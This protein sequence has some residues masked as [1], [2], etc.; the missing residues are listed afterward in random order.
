MNRSTT[1]AVAG[2]TAVA[3]T[4]APVPASAADSSGAQLQEVTPG[5]LFLANIDDDANAC[6]SAAQR[7]TSEAV[8]R[9]EAN[10]QRFS[11]EKDALAQLPDQEQAERDFLALRRSHRWEQ[12]LADRQLAACNDAA[13]AVVNGAADER[14]L[15]RLRVTPWSNAPAAATA[16]VTTSGKVR[17]FVKRARWEVADVLTV[18]ELRRGVDLGL[19]GTDVVRD[20][21]DWDG[22]AV[23]T[24]TVTVAGAATTRAV[25]LRAAPVLTQLNTQRLQRVFAAESDDENVRGWHAEIAKVAPLTTLATADDGWTQDLFEPAYQKVDGNGMRVLVP[26]VN[27]RHRQAA[28]A[29]YTQLRGRDVAVVHIADVPQADSD[30]DNTYDSMGNLETMPPTPGHPNGTIVVG[31]TPSARVMTFFRAQGAQDVVT[32]DTGWLTVGHVDEFIQFLPVDGGWKAIVAD[33]AAGLTMLAGVPQKEKLH[34]NLP[35]LEWPYDERIDK[36]TVAEFRADDQF[37]DTNR[38]AARRIDQNIA[39][40]G[41]P[42]SRIVRIPV[43][44]TARSFDW[45]LAQ[46]AIDGMDDG[47]EKDDAIVAL[48]AM[49]YAVGETPNLINGLVVNGNRYVAPKP[50]GPLLGGHDVFETAATRALATVGYQVGYA[51]DL[52]SAHVG[53]G[54]IHCSTNT[55]RDYLTS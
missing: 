14:D 44:F 45:A 18:A 32:V 55:F 39:T 48:N 54:E 22:T 35:T 49:R 25:R 46:S 4:V 27:D 42:A 8:A 6:R 20:R 2:L 28:R 26:S 16:R 34:G 38:I 24:L 36:R 40:L 41:L 3:L 53:E 10:E 29:A 51:D 37:V 21:A 11:D 7:I 1:W 52:T 9:E 17:L 5:G 33:P 13:D 19:E 47:P 50:Y 30:D 31:G 43:L 23:V 15:F 12:N